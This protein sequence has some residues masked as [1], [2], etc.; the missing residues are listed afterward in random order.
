MAVLGLVEQS[1]SVKTPFEFPKLT[2]ADLVIENVLDQYDEYAQGNIFSAKWVVIVSLKNDPKKRYYVKGMLPEDFARFPAAQEKIAKIIERNKELHAKAKAAAQ[3]KQTHPEEKEKEVEKEDWRDM[4]ISEIEAEREQYVA[5]NIFRRYL[6]TVQ[7]EVRTIQIDTGDPKNPRYLV[8]SREIEGFI[9]LRKVDPNLFKKLMKEGRVE[10]LGEQLTY[11]MAV[12]EPDLNDC[13]IGVVIRGNKLVLVRIDFGV[14]LFPTAAAFNEDLAAENKLDFTHTAESVDQA[15]FTAESKNGER[16][17]VFYACADIHQKGKTSDGE[18]KYFDKDVLENP[19]VQRGKHRATLFLILTANDVVD[20]YATKF[21][22]GITS[23]YKDIP[24]LGEIDKANK[25]EYRKFAHK[26]KG[27]R[28]YYL[29]Q[30]QLY[31]ENKQPN[32]ITDLKRLLQQSSDIPADKLKNFDADV[33]A[34]TELVQR[35]AG[36][37]SFIADE[38]IAIKAP[39]KLSS[40]GAWPKAAPTTPTKKRFQKFLEKLAC[41]SGSKVQTPKPA[42]KEPEAIRH[43]Y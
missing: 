5:E 7:P 28:D 23:E 12:N 14:C 40:T 27:F 8:L 36:A 6:P 41:C 22:N 13:N 38:K 18:S 25:E 3:K 33:A 34:L 24:S 16:H 4:A 21:K 20:A 42:G 10:F 37:H 35:A 17:Y 9:P 11:S 26:L 30:L 15:P 31:R 32:D 2:L 39:V 29:A 1:E 43:T 19:K